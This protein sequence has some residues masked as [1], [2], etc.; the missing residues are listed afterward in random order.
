MKQI[1]PSDLK[2]KIDKNEDIFI[3][4]VRTPQEY[5]SWRLSYDRHKTP[6]LI[7]VDSLLVQGSHLIKE[8]PKDKEIH[9]QFVR[10]ESGRWLRRTSSI[11]WGMMFELKWRDGGME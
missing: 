8:I 6:K 10:T 11:N 5:E 9:T 3:L 2:K 7:P 4:D 1:N